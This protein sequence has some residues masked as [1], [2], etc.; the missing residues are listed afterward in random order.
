MR[1]LGQSSYCVGYAGLIHVHF[2]N[3]RSGKRMAQREG[4]SLELAFSGH[5]GG[6]L[7]QLIFGS[8]NFF[9]SEIWGCNGSSPRRFLISGLHPI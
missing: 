4:C 5:V 1:T 8:C 3:V 7:G 9:P 2:L 6:V